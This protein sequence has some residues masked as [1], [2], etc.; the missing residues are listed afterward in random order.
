MELIRGLG[1][2]HIYGKISNIL[3]TNK[4]DQWVESGVMVNT[5]DYN[6][7]KDNLGKHLKE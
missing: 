1:I 4:G 2:Q 6:E 7:Q 3:G 5:N